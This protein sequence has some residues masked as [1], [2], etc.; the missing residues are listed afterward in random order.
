MRKLTD[1]LVIAITGACALIAVGILIALVAVVAMR[2]APALSWSFFTEQ[3]RLVGAEGGI[4]YNLV[5]TAILI[6][7]ALL[8]AAPIALGVALVHSVYLRHERTRRRLSDLHV[9]CEKCK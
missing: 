4:F 1:F 2:G 8:V 5:G 7:T 6:I 3:I 9:A